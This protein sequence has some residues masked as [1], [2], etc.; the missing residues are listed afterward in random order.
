MEKSTAVC[1]LPVKLLFTCETL[2]P[3]LD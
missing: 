1:Y 2:K 3:I